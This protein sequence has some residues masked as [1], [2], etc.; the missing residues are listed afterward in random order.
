MYAEL[1]INEGDA[2]IIRNA[3]GS[4]YVF[5]FDYQMRSRLTRLM[6]SS[7]D[8][9]R[10]IIISQRLL[11][12]REIAVF[13]HTD[14]GMLTFTTAEL[15]DKVKSL[16][17]DPATAQAVD[18]ID[19]LEFSDLEQSVKDDVQ[20]LKENPLVLQETEVSG[21]VY[22]VGT[23]KVGNIVHPIIEI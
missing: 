19:F 15:R 23:G 12:T 13:H 5:F 3:G 1:G 22:E 17:D 9:L 20:Y 11:G 4:A 6:P 2:H 8:A 21:W 16:T 10:S 18:N 7:K 14:C